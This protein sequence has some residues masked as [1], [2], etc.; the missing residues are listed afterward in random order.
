MQRFASYDLPLLSVSS[1]LLENLS[2]GNWRASIW[3]ASEASSIWT[4]RS[5]VMNSSLQSCG[6]LSMMLGASA[7]SWKSLST[8]SLLGTS[9]ALSLTA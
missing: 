7:N 8:L 2:V 9:A 1:L 6:N 3:L 4:S 5:L